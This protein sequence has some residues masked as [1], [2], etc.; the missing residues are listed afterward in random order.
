MLCRHSSCAHMRLS[1]DSLSLI[2]LLF[3]NE[4]EFAYAKQSSGAIRHHIHQRRF[5]HKLQK[6]SSRKKRNTMKIESVENEWRIK[7]P[8][9]VVFRFV[10]YG[11]T[12]CVCI[13]DSYAQWHT[14]RR[15]S[16]IL[17]FERSRHRL[18]YFCSFTS[19]I[20][21]AAENKYFI[22]NSMD[23]IF[24]LPGY[25][26]KASLS[27]FHLAIVALSARWMTE[28][29]RVCL[30]VWSHFVFGISFSLFS[31]ASTPRRQTHALV[32]H[33]YA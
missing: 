26:L 18:E 24:L 31:F 9:I 5:T 29:W 28:R 12:E 23:Y 22:F 21:E 17:A 4:S 32:C 14:T 33:M 30:C 13:Y 19:R 6:K 7:S 3:L 27:G 10:F 8:V 15:H 20:A 1:G 16:H 2:P 25:I 11:P